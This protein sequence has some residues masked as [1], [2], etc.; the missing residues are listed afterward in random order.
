VGEI[1][2]AQE[3]THVCALVLLVRSVL[4]MVGKVRNCLV[5]GEDVEFGTVS[6][7]GTEEFHVVVPK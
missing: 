7:R 1:L 3:L 5:L 6:E 2:A 4:K